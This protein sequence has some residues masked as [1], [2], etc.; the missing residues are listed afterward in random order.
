MTGQI[1]QPYTAVWVNIER[2]AHCLVCG[3]ALRNELSGEAKEEVSLS[4]LM[5]ATGVTLEEDA[6]E[7]G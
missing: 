5:E 6:G 2:D 4:D 1:S 7:S 3:D